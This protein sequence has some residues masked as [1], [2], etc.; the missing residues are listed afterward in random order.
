MADEKQRKPLHWIGSSLADIR[1]MPDD[2]KS[3]FGFAIDQAETGGK[4]LDAKPLKGFG[5]AGVL[6]VIADDEGGTYRA[7]Y[8]VKFK[9]AV[10]VLHVFQKKSKKGIATPAEEID[11]IKRR[12]K[13]AELHHKEKYE[14]EKPDKASRK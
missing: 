9:H 14:Q 12:L 10:Y 6:E 4:H 5:G 7:V 8:T 11:K 1:K 3:V 2:V 13:I